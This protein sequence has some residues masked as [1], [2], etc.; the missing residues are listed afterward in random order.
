MKTLLHI[1]LLLIPILGFPQGAPQG[2]SYQAVAYDSEGFEIS[3]QDISVRLGILLGA[4]DAED[5]YT[6]V[7]SVT[8]DDFGLFSLV[9]SQG[10]TLD[11][12]SSINWEEGAYLKVEVDA[13]LDG[14]YSI[15]GVS[16]FN[17]VPYAL[18]AETTKSL[19]YE[20]EIPNWIYDTGLCS[21]NLPEFLQ[22]SR[23]TIS[24]GNM[25][26]SG[27]QSFCNFTLNEGHTLFIEGSLVLRVAGVLTINGLIDGVGHGTSDGC[28][29]GGNGGSFEWQKVLYNVPL[30]WYTYTYPES[31]T[32]IGEIIIS[33][34]GSP[35]EQ[36]R[37]LDP[38]ISSKSN[39]SGAYGGGRYVFSSYNPVPTG[40]GGRGG[41]GLVIICKDFYFNGSIELNGNNGQNASD[42]VSYQDVIGASGGGGSGS[43][44]IN[45]QNILTN[46]GE[47][48]LNGGVG[49]A[50][51]IHTQ[52]QNNMN[53]FNAND[54]GDG[55]IIWL[56]QD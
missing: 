48:H 12:F 39:L 31:G 52:Y 28:V 10:E 33:T 5:S 51:T 41:A 46:S 19:T 32:S 6:E 25:T 53:L 54:G 20:A 7:H 1:F 27:D 13:N 21:D 22:Y 23:D 15:M 45:A 16:S 8:T 35:V 18:Y 11:T 55:F 30:N 36:K 38:I 4:V 29:S 26:L 43:V 9:I 56:N 49:G 47:F 50:G 17:A 44:I 42:A 40:V 34:N 14:E 24:N 3:N 2:I 37:Y